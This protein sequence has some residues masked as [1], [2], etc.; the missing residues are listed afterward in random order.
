MFLVYHRIQNSI[1]LLSASAVIRKINEYISMVA[2]S[3]SKTT[4]MNPYKNID[5][6]RATFFFFSVYFCMPNN[7]V[8][9]R[10]TR[11]FNRF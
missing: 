8:S 2:D 6:M 9:N 7:T 1:D 3:F 10:D 4:I 11:F 5:A